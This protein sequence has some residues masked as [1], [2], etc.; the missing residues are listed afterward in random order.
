MRRNDLSHFGGLR[1]AG[2]YYEF[3]TDVVNLNEALDLLYHATLLQE[4]GVPDCQIR[5]WFL[6]GF[7]AH[8]I[9][10]TLA[11]VGLHLPDAGGA[12]TK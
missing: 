6:E 8:G 7:K 12:V 4:I 3:L 2:R 11:A 10:N 9:R 5:S 1:E